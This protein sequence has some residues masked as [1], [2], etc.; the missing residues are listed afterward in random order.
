MN[1]DDVTEEQMAKAKACKTSEE[2][3][4]LAEAEGVVLT[5]EQL[6]AVSGGWGSPCNDHEFMT[7]M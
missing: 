2:L 7:D 1:F 4:A 6:D 5:D 3:I